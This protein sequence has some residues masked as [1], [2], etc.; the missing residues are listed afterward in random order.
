[1]ARRGALVL[2]AF[3]GLFA[4]QAL[5]ADS[6]SEGVPGG[7]PACS[8]LARPAPPNSL[9]VGLWV[10]CDYRVSELTV[11]SSDRRFT[12]VPRSAELLGASPEDS[13][14]CRRV[15]PRKADCD[16]RVPAL[17][18]LHAVLKIDEGICAKPRLRLT[19]YAF[20]GP[21][22]TGNCSG[23]GFRTL[24]PSPTDRFTMGCGGS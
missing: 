11:R 16:G 7:P 3:L 13:M 22:C 1:M 24:T 9:S 6:G 2:A 21:E 14:A 4:T 20:G 23:I 15:G 5:G 8:V 19:V 18:R 12:F 17:A 10:Q